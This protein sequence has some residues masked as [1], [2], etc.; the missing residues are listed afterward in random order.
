MWSEGVYI[1]AKKGKLMGISGNQQAQPNKNWGGNK[2][3]GLTAPSLLAL[4]LSEF[5]SGQLVPLSDNAGLRVGTRLDGEG[6]YIVN[7][8]I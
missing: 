3:L 8:G 4:E 6:L 5:W 1:E 7:G 2:I